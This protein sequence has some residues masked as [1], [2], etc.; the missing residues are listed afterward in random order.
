MKTTLY[1]LALIMCFGL[2]CQYRL[3]NPQPSQ[4]ITIGEMNI[5]DENEQPLQNSFNNLVKSIASMHDSLTIYK[6]K[7]LREK[8]G[9]DT[10]IISNNLVYVDNDTLYLLGYL[11]LSV[12]EKEG[13]TGF[14]PPGQLN[15]PNEKYYFK[16][17]NGPEVVERGYYPGTPGMNFI[18]LHERDCKYVE[19]FKE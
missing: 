4:E 8:T 10:V 18:Q 5:A 19:I 16:A 7:Y 2:T 13:T 14:T 11:D 9:K 3:D 12:I 17:W 1:T 6:A 15:K